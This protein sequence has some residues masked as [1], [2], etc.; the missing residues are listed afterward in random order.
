MRNGKFK[1]SEKCRILYFISRVK[2]LEVVGIFSSL[3]ACSKSRVISGVLI[4]RV[5]Y[6]RKGTDPKINEQD[7]YTKISTTTL[8]G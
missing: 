1:I 8:L 4:R 7:R 5:A 6:S 3:T 2:F